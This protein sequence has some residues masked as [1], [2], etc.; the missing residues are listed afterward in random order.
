MTEARFHLAWLMN[1]TPDEWNGPFGSGGSPWSGDF[2]IEMAQTLERACFSYMI[3]EDTLM[4]SQAYGGSMEAAEEHGRKPD[5]VKVLFLGSRYSARPKG[6]RRLDRSDG[7]SPIPI[8][9]SVWPG[10]C[11][12][13]TWTSRGSRSTSR[14]P[15]SPP[16]AS[17][18]RST[19]SRSGEAARPSGNWRRLA[20]PPYV[21]GSGPTRGPGAIARS[22]GGC[23]VNLHG[24][25]TLS[26]TD[27]L[28]HRPRPGSSLTVVDGPRCYTIAA[29]RLSWASVGL[30]GWAATDKAGQQIRR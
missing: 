4:I 2:Y 3:I 11:R 29:D 16:T 24:R 20:W 12:S 18:G 21:G 17:R 10:S 9:W 26:A 5:D 23:G 30:D 19:S 1:F 25:D 27:L 6:S 8:W 13:P 28:R 7:G 22:E 14:W 15:S